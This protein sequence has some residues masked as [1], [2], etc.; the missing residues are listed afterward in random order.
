MPL[1]DL[2]M[3]ELEN[4]YEAK[5]KEAEKAG[6]EWVEAKAEFESYDDK[7]KPEIAR[8]MGLHEGS[9]AQRE[10]LAL[11][12]PDWKAFLSLIAAERR[13]YLAATV[14]YDMAKLKIEA[15]RTIIS[16]RRE[17]VKNFRG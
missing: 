10:M 7:R 17:E 15:I 9:I 8:L 1:H 16:T 13:R 6:K 4:L 11:S 14:G 3:A 12:H 2:S 5:I